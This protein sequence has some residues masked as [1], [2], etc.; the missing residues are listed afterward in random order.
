MTRW[1]AATGLRVTVPFGALFA[2]TLVTLAA[3]ARADDRPDDDTDYGDLKA[4]VRH[5]RERLEQQ[6]IKIDE[7]RAASGDHWLTEQRAEEIRT[8]VADVL[9]DADTR[10]NEQSGMMAGWSEH[11]F[12]ASPDGRFKLQLEGQV[13][14]RFI[15]NFLDDPDR[16]R[17][18]FE[19]TR[20]KLT[21]RGHVFSPDLTFLVRTDQ[22]RNEPGLVEGLFFVRDVWMALRLN[23]EWTVRF[24]QFKLPFNREELVSSAYQLAVERTL[25][26]ESY[27]LGRS[28]GVELT[29]A[30][31]TAKLS[32]AYT[33]GA[34][35]SVGGFGIVG[36]NRVNTAAL[37]E[38]TEY[39]VTMRYERLIAGE[40][41]QFADFTSRI[42]DEYGVLV[43]VAGHAEKTESNG[44][45]SRGN[46]NE[47]RW[48]AMTADL[49]IEW[50]GATAFIAAM[51]HWIDTPTLNLN[52]WGF[53][54]QY[55]MYLSPK[56]EIFGRWEYGFFDT[57]A[58]EFTNLSV[59][60]LGANYYIDGHDL[61]WTSDISFGIDAIDQ[62]W[63]FSL[64]GY[65]LDQADSEP[66]I[67]IRTQFQLLF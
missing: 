25:I 39:A 56:W 31:D 43:G 36:G 64:P 62:P 2:L 16:H 23:N 33:D 15:Y 13:Q 26:N 5:L 3:P 53:V 42:G 58:A 44:I 7:L 4:E 28:E 24:G 10:V 60:T 41:R 9:A 51:Y 55:G 8:L 48:A 32:F 12:L 67:V 37:L 63:D 66:Q 65:R 47:T 14:T 18:G 27:N 34:V 17:A 46:R 21:A 20:T 54:V 1:M 35:D 11:F 38:D 59:L 57:R 52:A 29:Y 50:G 49:S 40:W 45:N 19:V 6:A 22:T 30:D 61:K